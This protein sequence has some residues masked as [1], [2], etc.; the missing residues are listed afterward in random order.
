MLKGT[1]MSAE[2]PQK[3]LRESAP[4]RNAIKVTKAQQEVVVNALARIAILNL[5]L[6]ALDFVLNP[7]QQDKYS[8]GMDM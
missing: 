4:L 3:E 5:R 8:G 2:D 7:I 6:E 1:M